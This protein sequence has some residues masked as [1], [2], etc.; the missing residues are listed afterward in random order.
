MSPK[1]SQ[2]LLVHHVVDAWYTVWPPGRAQK[3]HS[4]RYK[5]SGPIEAPGKSLGPAAGAGGGGQRG[6]AL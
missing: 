2:L 4:A 5:L 3:R 1:E 6:G